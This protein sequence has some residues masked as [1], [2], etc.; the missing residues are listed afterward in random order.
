MKNDINN[1]TINKST[2]IKNIINTKPTFKEN[3]YFILPD[4][5]LSDVLSLEEIEKLLKDKE[6]YEM[7]I[8]NNKYESTILKEYLSKIDK[9]LY[10]MDRNQENIKSYNQEDK[11]ISNGIN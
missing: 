1:L 11:G 2:N 7:F 10:Q 4:I 5:N 3:M 6:M 9:D 8:K